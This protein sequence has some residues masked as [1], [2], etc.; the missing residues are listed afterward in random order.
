MKIRGDDVYESPLCPHSSSSQA[1]LQCLFIVPSCLIWDSDLQITETDWNQLNEGKK[2]KGWGG[3]ICWKTEAEPGFGASCG[4]WTKNQPAVTTQSTALSLCLGPHV[5]ICQRHFLE[6]DH[7][8]T[9]LGW[10]R[11]QQEQL[12]FISNRLWHAY[13]FTGRSHVSLL[14]QCPPAALANNVSMAL[15]GCVTCCRPRTYTHPRVLLRWCK[16]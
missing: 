8:E 2:K 7:N 14:A 9:L 12:Q 6:P 4:T 11:T 10:I 1:P 13:V 3:Q 16:F 5:F 15:F